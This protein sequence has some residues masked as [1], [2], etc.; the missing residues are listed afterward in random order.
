MQLRENTNSVGLLQ[1]VSMIQGTR[2]EI[3]GVY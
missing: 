3:M 1:M 2:L